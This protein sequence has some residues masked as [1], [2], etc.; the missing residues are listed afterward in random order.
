MADKPL[1]KID[2]ATHEA[3]KYAVENWHYS[4]CM[5]SASLFKLGVWEDKK[6]IGVVIFG[7][8][9]S[10]QIFKYFKLEQTEL[11]ELVRVALKKHKTSVS[12]I[13]SVCIR[14]LK[15][16]SPGL[17]AIVSFADSEQGHF[18]IIYQAG[19]WDYLGESALDKRYKKNGKLHH[20]RSLGS[21]YGNRRDEFL[22][23]K[24]YEA[25]KVGIKYRYCFFLDKKI[26][27]NYKI[28]DY[29]KC[30]SSKDIVASFDQKEEGGV[31]PTDALQSLNGKEKEKNEGRSKKAS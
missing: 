17:K 1:L 27:N 25:V 22:K 15:K 20:P 6:F 31:I 5:P 29:P 8:G 10:P 11:C 7:R 16:S 2:W 3:A 21:K 9:A 18:G 28:M 23:N 24:G 14:I 4:K 26:R 12:K 19:N 13:I 30:A